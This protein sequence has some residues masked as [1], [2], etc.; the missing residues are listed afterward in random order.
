MPLSVCVSRRSCA[1]AVAKGRFSVEHLLHH[2]VH[3]GEP[4]VRFLAEAL[5][6]IGEGILDGGLGLENMGGSFALRWRLRGAAPTLC[7]PTR[8]QRDG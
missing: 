5:A 7:R 1:A 3:A 8:V 2:P 6:Q 4:F